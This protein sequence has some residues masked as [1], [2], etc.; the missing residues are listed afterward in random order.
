MLAWHSR[1]C[2]PCC[3][4]CWGQGKIEH[5][6]ATCTACAGTLLMEFGL[7]SAL[8]GNHTYLAKADAAAKALYERRSGL[9][10][11]GRDMHLD[12]G[13]WTSP[14]ATIGPGV[15][16]YYEYLLKVGGGGALGVQ[17]G[18]EGGHNVEQGAAHIS[19]RATLCQHC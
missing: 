4:C 12:S 8:T 3:C 9:G 1:C 2:R 19:A 5:N 7:L 18:G 11:V 6:N 15:D 13:A 10:L 14:E 16:S 17:G